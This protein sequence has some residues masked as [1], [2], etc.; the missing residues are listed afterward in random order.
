MPYLGLSSQNY[1]L[2]EC[3]TLRFDDV[4]D[5]SLGLDFGDKNV[6]VAE[7]SWA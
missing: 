1:R 4:K 7:A 5:D 3:S 6:R 2:N